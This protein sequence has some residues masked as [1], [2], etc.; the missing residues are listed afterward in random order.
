MAHVIEKAVNGHTTAPVAPK[1]ILYT[2][3]TCPWAHRAHTVLKALGLKHEEVIIPLDRPR[4]EWYLKE[5][6]PRGLVPSLKVI[7]ED[8]TQ[9]VITESAIVVSFLLDLAYT[10][11]G[12]EAIATQIN[13]PPTTLNRALRRAASTH[14]VD[15]YFTKVQPFREKLLKAPADEDLAGQYISVIRKEL[16]PTLID[17]NPYFG[18]AKDI[19]FVEVLVGSQIL[20]LYAVLEAG[21]LGNGLEKAFK[22]MVPR[23][24][25]W[26]TAVRTNKTVQA[27]IWDSETHVT[28]AKARLENSKAK[29]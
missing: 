4:E 14:F 27:G 25:A 28:K 20:R 22:E 9:Y 24:D 23:F 16:E 26:A 10:L 11:P 17:A 19:T 1:L 21:M 12:F 7:A 6:N 2:C 8:N 5:I 18:G 3:H 29:A 15:T 13:P